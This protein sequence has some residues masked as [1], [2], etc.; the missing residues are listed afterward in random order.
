[1]EPEY[2]PFSSNEELNEII[3]YPI[4]MSKEAFEKYFS[5]G[6]SR[7]SI[8]NYREFYECI[9]E[10]N[11]NRTEEN[12][13]KIYDLFSNSK[14]KERL[15]KAFGFRRNIFSFDRMNQRMLK[16]SWKLIAI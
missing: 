12:L 14:R 7:E 6:K 4:P 8:K 1:M 2:I 5:S 3:K 16:N 9:V 11:N 10:F 15:N 13:Q